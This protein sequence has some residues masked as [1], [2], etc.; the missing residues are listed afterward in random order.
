MLKNFLKSEINMKQILNISKDVKY[1]KPLVRLHG[2]KQEMA[3]VSINT[4]QR[5]LDMKECGSEALEMAKEL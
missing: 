2:P 5:K 3:L 1:M 4:L